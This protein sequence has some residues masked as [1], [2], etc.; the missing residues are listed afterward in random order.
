MSGGLIGLSILSG[1]E[2]ATNFM[3]FSSSLTANVD[4]AAVTKAKAA[5]ITP[6]TV[7]PW[8]NDTPLTNPSWAQLEQIIG[9]R[10]IISPS[11]NSAIAG[12]PDV[13]ATF[14][15]YKALDQLRVLAE[16][17]AKAGTSPTDRDKLQTAFNKGLDQLKTYLGSAVT[18]QLRLGF[19]Q[20]A[21]Q[22]KSIGVQPDV[23]TKVSGRG[24]AD[25]RDDPVAGLAGNEVLRVSLSKV[26]ASTYVDV[27]LSTVN[28]G[29]PPTLDQVA[30]AL[31][32][33]I[34][35]DPPINQANGQPLTGAN[36]Q[37]LS[38]F[39]SKFTVTKGTDGEW[40][41]TL[42][43]YGVETIGLDE[44]SAPNAV[45][46]TS[47]QAYFANTGKD[48]DKTNT[49]QPVSVMR[50]DNLDGSAVRTVVGT[51]GG[52]DEN[53]TAVARKEEADAAAALKTDKPASWDDE[54]EHQ[55][56][57]PTI[58][59]QTTANA[60]VTDADGFTYVVGTTAGKVGANV[61]DGLDDLFLTK[62]DSEGKVVWQHALGEVGDAKGA[63]ISLAPNGD[64]VV[65]GTVTG[66]LKGGT[67]TDTNMLVTRFTANGEQTFT[68]SFG[69]LG[70][71]SATAVTVGADGSIYVGGKTAAGNGNA[72]VA[73]VDGT[74]K[75]LE[76]TSLADSGGNDFVSGLA[77]D[78][79]GN[80]LVLTREGSGSKIHQLSGAALTTETGVIDLGNVDA[81]SIAV[82]A[83]GKIAVA[84]SA[85]TP[86]AAGTQ[87]NALSGGTD[88]FVTRLDAGLANATTSYVGTASNDQIDSIA[89]MGDDL[90]VGGRTR[91]LLSG[92]AVRGTVDG[93]VGK[94]DAGGSFTVTAQF[95]QSGVTTEPVRVSVAQNGGG[96]AVR[97][98]GFSRGAINPP[99]VTTL[100][101]QTNLHQP[102][103]TSYTN[104]VTG[105][106]SKFLVGGDSFEIAVDGKQPR[107]IMIDK[108]ETMSTL[109]DKIRSI[110]G[111]SA[112]VST[113]KNDD[114]TV[115]LQILGKDGHPVELIAG[116]KGS[117]ALA[118]LG[119]TPGKI[120]IPAQPG[121][122]DPKVR[123][124][125]T[126]G[127]N[128]DNAYDLTSSKT[129]QAAAAAINKAISMIQT[130]YRSL[131]WS[132][133]DAQI[134]DGTKG[135]GGTAYQ[136]AQ[137][138]NYKAGLARLSGI[139]V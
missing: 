29:N 68:T 45:M 97:S 62:M 3:N 24:V 22:V 35:Q 129:A 125:G 52:V 60:M 27:D 9:A 46:A 101:A 33:A 51:I 92:L 38:A 10:T 4:S 138:A 42:S 8:Q 25:N 134:V 89:F 106:T 54:D 102:E 19:S 65:A 86:V 58:Y 16:Q 124:G 123:P 72:Y 114:G 13:Q 30:A 78:N 48:V 90:Y 39:K 17:A 126:Y 112:F 14:T 75:V 18:D 98:L 32:N 36:G 73:R 74:G 91:G 132:S 87:A 85:S 11:S 81:R 49:P 79:S 28:G 71:D 94:L 115:S 43:P 67:S 20:P 127:L 96:S 59:K 55:I 121:K 57:P 113:T 105:K 110:V 41:L 77:V 76:R 130:A 137:L 31:N 103:Y 117:D 128:L 139:S 44:A 21:T 107:S 108:T 69:T 116:P 26:G 50:F 15:T 1:S 88:G 53:A 40:G 93:F 12:L 6:A 104:P 70:N 95:G 136:A 7:A 83:N 47:G 118:A 111:D 82:S 109:A 63:A 23:T 56:T 119:I 64:V 122:D 66:D 135:G 37:V 80:L 84:G 120:D 61:S 100:V 133:T 131:Y 2:A 99:T 34:S 5:F